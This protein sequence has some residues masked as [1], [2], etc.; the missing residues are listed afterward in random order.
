MTF[1]PGQNAPLSKSAVIFRAFSRAPLDLSVLVADVDQRA[2]SAQDFVFYNQPATAGVQLDGEMVRVDLDQVSD[3]AVTVLCIASLDPAAPTTGSGSLE[4]LSTT[5]GDSSGALLGE[6]TIAP[7]V[8]ESAV[9]CWELYRRRGGWKVRAVGQGYG[10][11]LTELL[12]VHG[13]EVD[14]AP[15]NTTSASKR[16]DSDMVPLEPGRGLERIWMIFEDASRS[17][18][19]LVS[20]SDYAL[21]RLD[22]ELTLA[23]AE[24]SARNSPRGVAAREAAQRRHDELVEVARA[25]HERD[26]LQLIRELSVVDSELPAA[27]ASWQ[28]PVWARMNTDHDLTST[29]E[30][31]RLGELSA[32]DRSA[33][34]IPYCLPLPLRRPIWVDSSGRRC[35]GRGSGSTGGA[36]PRRRSDAVTRRRRPD[37]F[38]GHTDRAADGDS[39]RAGDRRPL[40]DHRTS[41][42]V[43]RRRRHR[44]AG[45]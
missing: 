18:A 30:G 33:L 20:S 2:L 27:M 42:V 34:K 26:S 6:F 17:A 32:P 24:P 16:G 43:G 41:D 38:V 22:D 44:G 25:N 40:G 15:T 10:G 21:A 12:T 39:R 23:V 3:D 35:R 19:S 36:D 13:V 8:T 7:H 5:L 29:S 28:S 14:D 9:I 45:A 37:R 31:L 1:V 4:G 11:G